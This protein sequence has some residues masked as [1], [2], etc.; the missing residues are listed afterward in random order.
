MSDLLIHSTTEFAGLILRCLE[1][2]RAK[3]IVEIGAEFGGMSQL[4]ADHW[5]GA[6]APP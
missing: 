4:L 3:T 6:I 1:R 5:A 2:A